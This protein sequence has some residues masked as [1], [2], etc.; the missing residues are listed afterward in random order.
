[1]AT[2]PLRLRVWT[3]WRPSSAAATRTCPGLRSRRPTS[4]PLRLSC[5]SATQVLILNPSS[6]SS[7]PAPRTLD[8]PAATT[9][10]APDASMPIANENCPPTNCQQSARTGR[11][12]DV[13]GTGGLDH[14]FLLKKKK[15]FPPLNRH[16]L[17]D[18]YL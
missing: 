4:V 6:S 8:R 12:N 10:S 15:A 11:T 16:S 13:G 5:S 1:A 2:S 7:P 17:C 18:D 9:I 3:F 14:G